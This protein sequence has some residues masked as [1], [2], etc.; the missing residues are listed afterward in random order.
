MSDTKKQLPT[1]PERRYYENTVQLVT[2]D[3][4]EDSRMLRGYFAKFNKLSRS[5]AW[6]FKEKI[7]PGAFDDIDFVNDDIVAL[8]NHDSNQIV[9]RTIGTPK[10]IFGIDEVGAFYEFETPTTTVGND[11]LEN[12]KR[13]LVQHSSFSWPRGTIEDI[14][15]DDV[16][17]GEV[18]TILKFTRLIDVSPVVNPAY[19]DTTVDARAFDGAK[20]SHKNW[21]KE[22]NAFDSSKLKNEKRSLEI[23]RMR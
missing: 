5:I 14:W 6:G 18:R 17:H 2:R 10:L 12:V 4:E 20:E 11:L 19:S 21:K 23:E 9:G 1:G 22:N 13:G 3:G 8:F 7:K 16:E 15:E